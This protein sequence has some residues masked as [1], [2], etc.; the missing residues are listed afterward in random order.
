MQGIVISW[1]KGLDWSHTQSRAPASQ[2]ASPGDAWQERCRHA[3]TLTLAHSSCVSHDASRERERD[4]LQ[5]HEPRD[6]G[7]LLSLSPPFP[8]SRLVSSVSLPCLSIPRS[9]CNEQQPSKGF[10]NCLSL[11]L[12]HLHTHAHSHA[13]AGMRSIL[14][15]PSPAL[16]CS[17]VSLSPSLSPILA[18]F[19]QSHT[20]SLV[21]LNCDHTLI[22]GVKCEESRQRIREGI[23]F[24]F[25]FRQHF[26]FTPST[27]L[28]PLLSPSSPMTLFA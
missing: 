22:E 2:V 17:F 13:H 10:S 9:A 4:L 8:S 24:S 3:H 5:Q 19:S 21:Y 6:A 25:P 1:Q 28:S 14:G 27:S 26:S 23:V 16:P 18:F 20:L 11:S 7:F 15:F 12:P